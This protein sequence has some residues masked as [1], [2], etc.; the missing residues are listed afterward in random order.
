MNPRELAKKLIFKLF[1][2]G[3]RAGVH[4]LPS[5]YY[6]SLP[7]WKW[8]RANEDRWRKP[9]ALHGITWDVDEQAQ[10]L[11]DNV[12]VRFVREV[13]LDDLVRD[14]EAVG[15]IRYGPI[16]AQTLHAIVRARQP[17]R[18][19]E[20]GSGSSTL[21]MSQ[22]V[23]RNV[24]DGGSASEILAFDPYT[25]DLVDALP[26]VTGA[27]T[28]GIDLTVQDL[29]LQAGDLLFMDSTHAVRTGSEVPHIYL[30]L[31]PALPPGVLVHIHDMYLP[32]LFTPELY[33]FFF[34]WQ[35]TTLLAALLVHND[36]LAIRAGMAALSYERPGVLKELFAD[37]RPA[38]VERGLFA[39]KS[40]G[41]LPTS[42]WL[43][44]TGTSGAERP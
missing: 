15:G 33:D 31:L 29:G 25:A 8:L 14:S 2:I 9:I 32:Y 38:T 18:I 22:A 42:M 19:V 10:W 6:S 12:Q 44:T 30:N 35:E 41:H 37:Y 3:D 40:S 17:R 27:A 5:H 7:S 36:K 34:D 28:H 23:Q 11:R 13:R 20:I 4:V 39:K 24:E 16:E 26:H 21:V 1:F 43:E